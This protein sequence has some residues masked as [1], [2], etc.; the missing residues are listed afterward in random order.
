MKI[1]IDFGTTHTSAAVYD[2][3]QIRAIPLDPENANPNLLRSMIYITKAQEQ[4]L[5]LAAVRAF[6]EQDTGRAVIY[7]EKVVGTLTN[8]VA[9]HDANENVTIIYDTII[10]DDVGAQGRLLQSI[11]TGLRADSYKGT[12]IFGRYYTLQELIALLLRHVRTQAEAYLGM[13]I[14]QATLGRPVQF[15][16]DPAT[17]QYAEDRLREAALLAGFTAV[18]FVPE[19]VAAASFYVAQVTKAETVMVFDFGGGTLDLTVMRADAGRVHTLLATHGVLVGGDDLDSSIMRRHVAKY[20][21]TESAIDTNF[22]DRPL[23]FP[24]DLAD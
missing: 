9:S 18:D 14:H 24:E 11:K 21:G 13:P 1:G 8:T 7:E 19:P 16:D 10:E 15:S 12:A 5:G 20:F 3:K 22:D 4:F 17:D 2:G 6:L 23:L